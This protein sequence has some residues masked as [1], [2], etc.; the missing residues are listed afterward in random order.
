MKRRP[1]P[2]TAPPT[3]APAPRLPLAVWIVA[4]L[5]CVAP[6]WVA[7]DLPMVDLPQ[8]LYVLEALRHLHDAGSIFAQTFEAHFRYVPYLGYYAV[9]GTLQWLLPLEVANRVCLSLVVLAFP[10][11]VAM[12]LAAMR[13]PTWPALLAAPLAYGDNFAW[14]FVNTLMAT[15]LAVMTLALFVRALSRPEERAR[16]SGAC[17][18]VAVAGFLT[19]PAPLAF[20]VLAVPWA[21]L[22]TRAP[23]DAPGQGWL[24]GLRRRAIP[25]AGLLP[26]ALAALAWLATSGSEPSA[27]PGGGHSALGGLFAADAVRETLR[28]NLGAFLWLLANILQDGTDSLALLATIILMLVA[29]ITRLFEDAPAPA[30][31]PTWR[32]R[33]RPWG[34]VAI[35][36]A[37]FL[38]LPLTIRGQ[39]MYLSPRFAVLTAL[40]ALTLAPRLGRRSAA[41]LETSSAV[42]VVA[43]GLLLVR[44]FLAFD[45]EA[46]ALRRLAP[47]CSDAPRILAL[48]F[49]PYSGVVERPV[50]LHGAA[51]L[52]R[53]RHGLPN[54]TLAGGNQIPLRYRNGPPPALASEWHP[55]QFDAVTQ[56]A[57]FDHFLLRGA[58]PDSVFAGR[59]GTELE[60]AGREGEW[61]LVR[62]R[63]PSHASAD[64]SQSDS[65]ARVT[66]TPASQPSG[67]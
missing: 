52:A 20:L 8:H 15:P 9:V 24:D 25:L 42:T 10:L 64:T 65:A 55:E 47:A 41:V 13:R 17:A 27:A 6:L 5:A 51:V 40:L 63:S 14:G 29:P 32:E 19:H 12:L 23:D 67:R 11:S 58:R 62:R 46:S 22:T 56:G 36:F 31:R 1:K 45:H 59:L 48:I 43:G 60:L 16:C 21:L 2:P 33:V 4:S 35:A 7:R 38:A 53:L 3:P 49:D 44:G 61:S 39:I 37:L 28:A 34:L 66:R 50:Y 26:L 30:L 57:A 54:Y 18:V